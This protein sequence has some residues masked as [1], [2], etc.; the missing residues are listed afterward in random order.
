MFFYHRPDPMLVLEI[1]PI[2]GFVANYLCLVLDYLGKF[3]Y[4][5]TLTG[6]PRGNL[7]KKN[8]SHIQVTV[9]LP[10]GIPSL[11][12]LIMPALTLAINFSFFYYSSSIRAAR[13]VSAKEEKI[14]HNYGMN[15]YR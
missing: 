4:Y 1:N 15:L 14:P 12:Q 8:Y 3:L 6:W 10:D 2:V 13:K 11:G 7:L 9:I 5:K